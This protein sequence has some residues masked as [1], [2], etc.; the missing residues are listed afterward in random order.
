[1]PLTL[2]Y[3]ESVLDKSLIQEIG[4]KITDAFLKWHDL[5][6]NSVMTPNIT[7]HIQEYGDGLTLAGGVSVPGIWLE[8][9]TPSFAL[10][11][12][13]IQQGFFAEATDILEQYSQG[14]VE[15]RQIY[16]NLVHTVDGSWNL[17][18]RAMTNAELEEA[19]SQG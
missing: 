15:R 17:D 5:T 14:R 11:D 13:S 9:L 10:A 7:M 19:I 4:K 6:G 3:S 12:R 2:S 1:M 8:C 18:G 16:T